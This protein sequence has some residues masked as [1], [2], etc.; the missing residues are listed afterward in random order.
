MSLTATTAQPSLPQTTQHYQTEWMFR[1]AGET[2][3]SQAINGKLLH[4]WKSITREP[5]TLHHLLLLSAAQSDT[6]LT[7]RTFVLI[8]QALMER[9]WSTWAAATVGVYVCVYIG[10]G[11]L[12]FHRHYPTQRDNDVTS[13]TTLCILLECVVLCQDAEPHVLQLASLQQSAST[14]FITELLLIWSIEM[15][16]LGKVGALRAP[17]IELVKVWW[18]GDIKQAKQRPKNKMFY[19]ISVITNSVFKILRK[20]NQPVL[21]YF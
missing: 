7:L 4:P 9:L 8:T 15:Q 2:A 21:F 10:R 3:L 1:G 6:I 16:V 20:I 5:H 11:V 17:L 14:Q 13:L 12:R 18:C 19:Y